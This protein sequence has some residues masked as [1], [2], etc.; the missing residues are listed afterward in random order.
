M[1]NQ[2]LETNISY[3]EEPVIFQCQGDRLIGIITKPVSASNIGV[4]LIVGGPQYRSGSH[5]QFTLLSRHIAKQGIA[6][7]RFDYRGMG[8]SEGSP[9]NFEDIDADIRSA[10][11]TFTSIM[12]NIQHIAMW[13]LCDAASAALYYGKTDKRVT[14]LILLN[15][16]VHSE[17]G[18]ARARLKRYYV[19]R[20]LQ[21]SFWAKLLSGQV[22]L[23][24]SIG[25]LAQSIHQSASS[26]SGPA[27]PTDPR[28]GSPGYV[29]RMLRGL[30][31]FG[32]NV[33]IIL[34]GQDFTAAEFAELTKTN[35]DWHKACANQKVVVTTLK[36]ANHTFASCLWRN[37]VEK[38][39]CE[40]LI[41]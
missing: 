41:N 37:E 11:D 35:K 38:W 12:P 40:C 4:L 14:D 31:N 8:D 24:E 5:R 25:Q 22:K 15:P 30:N 28:H 26:V 20:L 33:Y 13:G 29:D 2:D 3:V 6:T 10:I 17:T 23:A 36:E 21:K 39:T 19:S 27:G 18:A 9:R 16:W 32:G 34:S 1:G 7:F